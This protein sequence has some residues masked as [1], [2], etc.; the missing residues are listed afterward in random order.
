VTG[1]QLS[2]VVIGGPTSDVFWGAFIKGGQD[3]AKNLG[4]SFEYMSPNDFS[5]AAAD[6]ARLNQVAI[7]K[8]PDVIVSGDFI[9]PVQDPILKQAI[10]AGITVVTVNSG[11]STWQGLG[12]VSF[13]GEDPTASGKKAGE[14][15]AAAGARHGVCVNHLVE[16]PV[17][18]QRC[19]GFIA[20]MKAAGGAGDTMTIPSTEG[21]DPQ[22]V[23]QDVQGYLRAHSST[24][25]VFTLGAAIAVNSVA[26]AKA[27]GMSATVKVGTCDLTTEALNDVKSGSISFV[28]DQ[29]PYLQTYYGV[30]IGVQERLYGMH[31]ISPVVLT[32]LVIDKNN[33]DKVLSVQKTYGNRGGN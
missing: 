32:P 17:L 25:F 24:D 5:N 23:T 15:A 4:V 2:V 7:T 16:N 14:L 30:L 18:Q 31:P 1:G 13:V 33:V 22:K 27:A 12:A 26:A 19:D 29:Q 11:L 10:D 8:K 20:A 3:A 6:L 9:P 28:I 21:S